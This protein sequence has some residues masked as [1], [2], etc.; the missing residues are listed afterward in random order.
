MM[1]ITPI[2]PPKTSQNV[3][4]ADY[5]DDNTPHTRAQGHGGLLS[6]TE[7]LSRFSRR[8]SGQDPAAL[9]V[10]SVQTPC[11]GAGA[12]PAGG[13]PFST[14]NDHDAWQI[15]GK[16]GD[17]D[18]RAGRIWKNPSARNR[19]DESKHEVEIPN[20]P[21]DAAKVFDTVLN[22]EAGRVVREHIQ[23]HSHALDNVTTPNK[24]KRAKKTDALN[25]CFC[26]GVARLRARMKSMGTLKEVG[27]TMSTTCARPVVAGTV[28]RSS[29]FQSAMPAIG[30]TLTGRSF[31][32]PRRSC[33]STP[34]W[35]VW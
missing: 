6:M 21:S 11:P 7:Q 13:E 35:S 34:G 17:E 5:T 27:L 33:T 16:T 10:I 15:A 28:A 12:G 14:P 25:A 20:E 8:L 1:A 3:H 26:D 31:A 18:G 22:E 29:R 23:W 19:R 30:R 24:N 32:Q 4:S 9:A 2:L